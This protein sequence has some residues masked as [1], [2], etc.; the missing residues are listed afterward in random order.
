MAL[1]IGQFYR[2]EVVDL[3]ITAKFELMR[4]LLYIKTNISQGQA[5]LVD[6]LDTNRTLAVFFNIVACRIDRNLV[7]YCHLR[8]L[9][10]A[11]KGCGSRAA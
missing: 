10:G 2:I 9:I 6:S 7:S 8:T 11:V 4:N 3:D 5:V 1:V